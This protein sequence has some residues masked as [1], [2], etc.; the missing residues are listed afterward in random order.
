MIEIRSAH[1][2]RDRISLV[3]KL[4]AGAALTIGALIA[5]CSGPEGVT[6]ECTYNVGENGVYFDPEG[7]EQFAVCS[8]AP[9][10]PAKCCTDS[11]NKPLTGDALTECLYGYGV[12]PDAGT[13]VDDAGDGDAATNDDAGDGG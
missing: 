2:R 13:T 5:A 9:D 3:A 7:C 1:V 6:P 11:K 4:F 10:D 12:I 8:K